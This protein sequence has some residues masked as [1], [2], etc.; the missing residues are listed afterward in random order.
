MGIFKEMLVKRLNESEAFE[1]EELEDIEDIP[2]EDDLESLDSDIEEPAPI[3]DDIHLGSMV[4]VQDATSFTAEELGIDDEDFG[5]FK[6]KVDAGEYAIVFDIDDDNPSLVDIVFEDGLEIFMIPRLVLAIVE[7]DEE[8]D[9][10]PTDDIEE[11][12]EVIEDEI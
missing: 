6:I 3:E 2:A 8:E 9:L 5:D 4:K 7:D 12:A 1:E 10:Q 11:D